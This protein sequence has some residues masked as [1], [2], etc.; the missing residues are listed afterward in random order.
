MPLFETTDA[1]L[2]AELCNSAQ[3]GLT[4]HNI[5]SGLRGEVERGKFAVYLSDQKYLG[6]NAEITGAAC[7]TFK[8]DW[9]HIELIWVNQTQRGQGLGSQ[10]MQKVEQKARDAG[11][12]GMH[13]TTFEFQAPEFYNAHGFESFAIL[14]DFPTQ[15]HQRH[16]MIKK[17]T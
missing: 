5:Q 1:K 14:E 16:Y 11:C 3:K 17:L 4:A 6:I 7:C 13:L 10:L 8:G 2:L 9:L 12:I 15:G